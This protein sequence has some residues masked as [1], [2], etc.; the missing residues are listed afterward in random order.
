MQDICLCTFAINQQNG[1]HERLVRFHVC[2]RSWKIKNWKSFDVL[3]FT[4]WSILS[5]C[6]A[7]VWVTVTPKY[8]SNYH[9]AAAVC[10]QIQLWWEFVYGEYICCVFVGLKCSQWSTSGPYRLICIECNQ[11]NRRYCPRGLPPLVQ[12]YV[13]GGRYPSGRAPM[14]H[15][16]SPSRS[17]IYPCGMKT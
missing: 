1:Y 15:S 16:V 6:P 10:I 8:M 3:L 2:L 7:I 4:A 17:Y 11:S 13:R 9:L 12:V 5:D 14:E